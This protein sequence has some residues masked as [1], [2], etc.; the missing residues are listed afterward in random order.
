M[1][2]SVITMIKP[3]IKYFEHGGT[4]RMIE[5]DTQTM[6]IDVFYKENLPADLTGAQAFFHLMEFST[7]SNIWSK[8]CFPVYDINGAI[9]DINYPYTVP[10]PLTN[11]DT[12]G[13]EGHYIGQLEL[14]DHTGVSRFP[15]Q[16]EVIISKN[17]T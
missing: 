10:V 16:V 3:S 9:P 15:F 8:E 1:K 2:K 13:L 4:V 12:L 14:I 7:R 11:Q 5:S 17:A 6:Y